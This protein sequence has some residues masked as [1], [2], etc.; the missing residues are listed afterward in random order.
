MGSFALTTN[1][2]LVRLV[3]F[4]S[5]YVRVQVF[6]EAK[7]LAPFED[8]IPL[9]LCGI[10]TDKEVTQ[11]RKMMHIWPNVIKDVAFA[12]HPQRLEAEGLLIHGIENA[13]F[14]HFLL[15]YADDAED[16]SVEA[17]EHGQIYPFFW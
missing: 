9:P 2:V 13:F 17:V 5:D 12:F 3:D 4:V 15:S 10:G 11:T 8:P 16:G 1:D 6:Q 14:C 7:E